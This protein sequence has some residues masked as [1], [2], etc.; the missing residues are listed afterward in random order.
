VTTDGAYEVSG[1]VPLART[2]QVETEYGEPIGWAPDAV[3]DAGPSY[4]LCRCGRSSTKPF[5]DGT[6][7]VVPFDGG[8]TADRGPR[9]ARAR[10]FPGEGVV[11]TD[12]RTLCEHAGHCGDRFTDVWR[13]IRDTAD[14]V[15]RDRLQRMVSLCPSGALEFSPDATSP[16]VE[17]DFVP[18]VAVVRD[19]PLW[20]R[21]GI[22]VESA[23]GTTYEVRN[24][25]TLCRCGQSRNKPFCDGSHAHAGFRD[26]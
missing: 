19:G 6:H 10:T 8:E 17:P 5:C 9:A 26:G 22:P 25:V 18:C 1:D 15:V 16:S 3:I 7:R 24:R 23:D 11:M 20:V 2:S 13:M 21:G 14:P 4:D 12:D